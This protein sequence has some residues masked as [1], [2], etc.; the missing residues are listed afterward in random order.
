MGDI[1]DFNPG[2]QPGNA[3]ATQNLESSEGMETV[4]LTNIPS[5]QGAGADAGRSELTE[6]WRE[7]GDEFK[8]LGTRL[9]SAIRTGWKSEQAQQQLSNLG[10]QLRAMADQV[11]NA[12]RS[13]RQEV[14]APETK[15]Q[16]ARAVEAAKG[17]QATLVEEVRDTVAKGLRAL[18]TQLQELADRLETGRKDR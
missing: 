8:K 9:A 13:A 17:A 2:A 10:D 6:D 16:V 11:E 15:A 7:V 14:Q 1:N 4:R 12:V 18:N 5:S 3:P